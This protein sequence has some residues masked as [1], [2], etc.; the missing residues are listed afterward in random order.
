MHI[1]EC[2]QRQIGE[3]DMRSIVSTCFR[4]IALDSR[5]FASEPPDLVAL[6]DSADRKHGNGTHMFEVTGDD[7]SR[8]ND[9]DLRTLVTRLSLAELGRL[10]LPLSGVT[11][12]GDQN[13]ADGGIDVRISRPSGSVAGDFIPRDETGIQVKLP[14]MPTAAII[15]EMRPN[16]A[17]RPVIAELADQG[18]AYVIV[19]AKGSVSDSSLRN[20]RAAMREAVEDH[21]AAT[22]LYTDFYDRERVANWLREY[23][24]ISAWVLERVGR[25][26]KG[27]QSLANWS[28]GCTASQPYIIDDSGCITN[29]HSREQENLTI[30]EGISRLRQSL[31]KPGKCV[32]LIGLSG[33]GKTRLVEALFESEVGGDPLPAALAVYTDNADEP[34]PSARDMARRF[35]GS[36]QRTILIVDNCNPATHAALSQICSTNGSAISLIT[37]EYDVRD[38]EPEG[39]EVFRLGTASESVIDKWLERSCPHVSQVDRRR[40]AAFSNG[41]FRVAK[42]LAHT[43]SK[44]ETLGT[45]NDRSLFER[46]FHQRNAPD[47]GLMI[48][49]EICS[50]VY[51]FDGEDTSQTS[52]LAALAA[53]PGQTIDQLYGHVSEL[54]QRSVLQTRSK[55]RAI[56][57]HA[58]ANRLAGLALDRISPSRF[59]HFSASLSPRLLKSLSRRLGYLHGNQAAQ[60]IT[61]R[62]LAPQGGL[63]DL[64]ALSADGL[65][66]LR[67]IAPV[68]P[69]AVLAKIEQSISGDAGHAILSTTNR[70]RRHWVGLLKA[71]AYE[72]CAFNRATMLLAKFLAA[73]PENYN[74]DSAATPFQEL[75]HL[76]LSGTKAPPDQR[77]SVIRQLLISEDAAVRECGFTALR[78]MFETHFFSAMSSIDFGARPR[79]FG[80]RPSTYGDIWAWY[81]DSIALVADLLVHAAIAPQLRSC[82][83]AN[84]SR[85]WFTDDCR[86]PLEDI[87]AT[88]SNEMQWTEG[89]IAVRTTLRFD[90][91]G[92]EPTALSRLKALEQ[93]LQPS[94]FADMARAYIF[95]K[96]WGSLD[97]ADGEDNDLEPGAAYTRAMERAE[98]FG[99]EIATMP[100]ML[101]SFLDDATVAQEGRIFQFGQGLASGAQDV[102]VIWLQI[103]AALERQ[104]QE[105]RQVD[106]VRGYF[107]GLAKRN[108][109]E[110]DR[111]LDD[112]IQH[113]TLARHFPLLQSIAG[114]NDR[115]IER[116]HT[117]LETG[118]ADVWSFRSIA[119][120]GV[121]KPVPGVLLAAF[122][123]RIE[124]MPNGSE[125]AIDILQMRYFG[126]RQD[127]IDIDDS[128]ILCGQWLLETTELSGSDMRDHWLGEIAS[129][130]LSGQQAEPAVR[131]I[132]RRI[133]GKFADHSLYSF[134][135]SH[136]LQTLFEAQPNAALDE[137]LIDDQTANPFRDFDDFD[138]FGTSRGSPLK[139]VGIETLEQW[140]M[141]N[142]QIRIPRLVNSITLFTSQGESEEGWSPIFLRL[143]ELAPEKRSFL[144]NV[145]HRLHPTGWSGSLADILDKRRTLVE[146]FIQ[147]SN[148]IIRAWAIEQAQRL[149]VESQHQRSRERRED[150]SFE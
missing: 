139:S 122:L 48:A 24:G 22:S 34:D 60:A 83:A 97:I 89:W 140:A 100:E 142:P 115:G 84:F 132:C 95:S 27:W 128:L 113:P 14:D 133:K 75:F 131:R 85:L 3:A 144:E 150:E 37:V 35:V 79:D 36:G 76:L 102:D 121:T 42:A 111:Y 93:R 88:I 130:C 137:F 39:T 49:A 99:A 138:D 147:H 61:A 74:F 118:I 51:S 57:P 103:M 15:A 55:W 31:I 77:R 54:K 8:L 143:L 78:A 110:L 52:E 126:D 101:E 26:V 40:I 25:A 18:G 80:W 90:G 20:R 91:K 17:L 29:E 16:G 64:S 107:S 50:L 145:N 94:N 123:R 135:A 46:I 45:L 112:A 30:L 11:A 12:G 6:A 70:T 4:T 69:D 68:A 1:G 104:P 117:S 33:L 96:P 129:V 59:D 7:I 92:M 28:E 72:S 66:I 127:G 124:S 21:P 65:E 67:N 32:R 19:S 114:L 71:L 109:P 86:K 43:I 2:P 38:D 41:N 56:L 23:P 5:A 105:E 47:Q 141:I 149:E 146:Q 82:L 98:A 10:A 53:L 116:L 81:T 62:W 148:P 58:I 73:Q 63:E 13:A 136:L 44:G 134:N 119:T 9:D 108:S 106:V 120:G 125:V 87:A